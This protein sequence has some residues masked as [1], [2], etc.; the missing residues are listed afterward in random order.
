M[1][2]LNY[3]SI[4]DQG[5]VL[6]LP[7]QKIH[8]SFLFQAIPVE[9]SPTGRGPKNRQDDGMLR[10]TVLRVPRRQQHFRKL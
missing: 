9:L 10:E 8:I 1:Q 5:D 4:R 2:L 7:F 6:K 3:I